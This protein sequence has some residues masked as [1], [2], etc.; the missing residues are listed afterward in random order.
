[1]ASQRQRIFITG[2]NGYIGSV[3]T[4]FAIAEGYEVHGL[5][6]SEAADAKLT[7]LGAVPVRGDLHSLD[8][9]RRESA[10]AQIVM[11]LADPFV[12]GFNKDYEDVIR[13]Q[14]AA[15]TAMGEPLKGTD[16]PLL[17]ASGTLM[18]DP[19]PNGGE[20]T[21]TS[22]RAKNPIV[23][24]LRIEDHALAL[25]AEGV[26]A[27]ILRFAPYVYGRG[28]SAIRLFMLM[29]VNTGGVVCVDGGKVRTSAIHVDDSARLCLS[30]GKKGK[31]GDIFNITS[32]TDVTARQLA[33]AIAAALQIPVRDITSEEAK[34]SLG[35]FFTLFL[36]SESRASSAKAAKELGWQPRGLGIL[37]DIKSGSYQA[38]A[39]E[40]QSSTS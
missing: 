1:M 10:Q 18:A 36:I 32:S 38:V 28:G 30:I 13:V 20:T 14:N 21:E 29:S 25:V 5:S 34:A 35:D 4:E 33:E 6:R 9:L 11:H 22:P 3:I 39:K 37:E 26:R 40:L 2:G 7:A 15:I 16:T 19:D 24:R 31:A 17:V 8:V 12:D 23:P 27:V